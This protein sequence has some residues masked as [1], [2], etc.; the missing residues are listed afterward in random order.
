VLLAVTRRAAYHFALVENAL[1]DFD[2]VD[3]WATTPGLAARIVDDLWPIPGGGR[4]Q[5]H[6]V[7]ERARMTLLP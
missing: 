7:P 4:C 3:V 5:V 2:H 6:A 1:Q